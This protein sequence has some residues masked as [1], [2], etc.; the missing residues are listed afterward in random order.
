MILSIVSN[1]LL[2][3]IV[4]NMDLKNVSHVLIDVRMFGIRNDHYV[5]LLVN[6]DYVKL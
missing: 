4:K 1:Q 6:S 3:V 5:S 2:L